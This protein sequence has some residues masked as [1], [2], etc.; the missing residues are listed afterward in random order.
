MFSIA[1]QFAS[2]KYSQTLQVQY[3]FDFFI[4]L[5]LKNSQEGSSPFAIATQLPFL[6]KGAHF[7]LS[8]LP[9]VYKIKPPKAFASGWLFCAREKI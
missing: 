1:S 3:T 5:A 7:R 2:T 4:H 6:Q 8:N 9:G